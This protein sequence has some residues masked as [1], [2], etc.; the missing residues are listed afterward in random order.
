M[1][2]VQMKKSAAE[3]FEPVQVIDIPESLTFQPTQL[4]LPAPGNVPDVEILK[5]YIFNGHWMKRKASVAALAPASALLPPLDPFKLSQ[6]LVDWIAPCTHEQDLVKLFA[7]G[8][9]TFVDVGA[10]V[11]TWTLNLAKVFRRVIAVEPNPEAIH[12]LR[13]N[14]ENNKI[15]NVEV[16]EVAASDKE[17]T[18]TLYVNEGPGLTSLLEQHP[19]PFGRDK[20]V[21]KV[22]VRAVA[23]DD[24]IQAPVSLIKVDVEGFEVEVIRGLLKTIQAQRPSLCIEIHSAK[25]GEA[26]REMLSDFTFV[27]GDTEGIRPGSFQPHLVYMRP[28]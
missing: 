6:R 3:G 9:D 19:N 25:N 5:D 22:S 26:I 15:T 18:A 2:Y 11:G 8:G 16:L 20:V 24:V 12:A 10:H 1:R 4:L 14:L 21:R 23:L 17:Y 7:A 28:K 27:D 13:E